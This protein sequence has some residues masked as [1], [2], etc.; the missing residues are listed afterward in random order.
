ME[1]DFCCPILF[2]GHLGIRVVVV[3]S[4]PSILLRKKEGQLQGI[5]EASTHQHLN[6]E[7]HIYGI[8]KTP[9]RLF[10]FLIY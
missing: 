10:E 9:F 3:Q 1:E 5:P 7:Y 2:S 6:I 4:M 8:R